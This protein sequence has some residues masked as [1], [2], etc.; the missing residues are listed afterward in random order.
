M[1]ERKIPQIFTVKATWNNIKTVIFL[2]S[3][4]TLV[5]E[6]YIPFPM[7]QKL[8]YDYFSIYFFKLNLIFHMTTS[9]FFSN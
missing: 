2:Y 1:P 6:I 7:C 4:V 9:L 3:S 5:W 8:S